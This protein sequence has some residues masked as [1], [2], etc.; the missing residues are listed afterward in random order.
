MTRRGSHIQTIQALGFISPSPTQAPASGAV[1]SGWPCSPE[2]LPPLPNPRPSAQLELGLWT[3]VWD[4]A[5]TKNQASVASTFLFCPEPLGALCE[6][7]ETR[8]CC[9]STSTCP[10]SIRDTVMATGLQTNNCHPVKPDQPPTVPGTM[11]GLLEG[12]SFHPSSSGSP[13]RQ[14][15]PTSTNGKRA[16]QRWHELYKVSGLQSG[17]VPALS[18]MLCDLDPR[19]GPLWS[20]LSPPGQGKLAWTFSVG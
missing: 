1:S 16:F 5:G 8:L 14:V 6:C 7:L 3:Q 9:S 13:V 11:L 15:S 10:P 20:S 12:S 17:L 2:G 19:P 18:Q 4:L